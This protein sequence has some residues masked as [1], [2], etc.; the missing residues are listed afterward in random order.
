MPPFACS[1]WE[2][3]S[4]L[5]PA[6]RR[7]VRSPCAARA[8]AS[9]SSSSMLLARASAVRR[10]RS[11]S[12]RPATCSAV[13]PSAAGAERRTNWASSSGVHPATIRHRASARAAFSLFRR[14]LRLMSPL[15]P[16]PLSLRPPLQP[17]HPL[18]KLDYLHRLDG[19]VEDAEGGL[20][21]VAFLP[22]LQ[23]PDQR[24][25]GL[26]GRPLQLPQGSLDHLPP[27]GLVRGAEGRLL[28]PAAQRALS[29]LG[30]LRRRLDG[31]AAEQG[32]QRPQ[33]PPVQPLTPVRHVAAFC[34]FL[35][36]PCR[37]TA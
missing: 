3:T 29:H 23:T 12:L 37:G 21:A 26:A 4:P 8:G 9:P 19:A 28:Q 11:W 17:G 14:A 18:L 2:S 13:S 20:D 33:L 34:R 1:T 27:G 22:G 16:G 6:P 30:R 31:G 32:L 24:P 10:A 5:P 36:L 15:A 35:P 7:A 25:D